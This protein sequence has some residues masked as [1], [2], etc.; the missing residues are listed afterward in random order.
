MG[1]A[2]VSQGRLF[3]IK[4]RL[5]NP[6]KKK[7]FSKLEQAAPRHCGKKTKIGNNQQND[8]DHQWKILK[9]KHGYSPYDL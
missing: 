3:W 6:F 8:N 1:N 5:S 7:N 2:V 9:S 4:Q